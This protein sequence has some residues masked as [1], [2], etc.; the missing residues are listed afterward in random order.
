MVS[1]GVSSNELDSANHAAAGV[2]KLPTMGYDSE[3][4]PDNIAVRI[5]RDIVAYNAFNCDYNGAL[6]AEQ[7]KLM[8]SLG[9]VAAGYNVRPS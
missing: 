1:F 4:G 7:A 6:A 8:K 3:C 2:G 5:L 9:L